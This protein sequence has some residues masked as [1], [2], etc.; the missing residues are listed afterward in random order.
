MKPQEH[1]SV[2]EVGD[3]VRGSQCGVVPHC[4]S[5]R[6]FILLSNE[7]FENLVF[8]AP[9]TSLSYLKALKLTGFD[10]FMH[11]SRR[12]LEEFCCFSNGQET[13][14]IHISRVKIIHIHTIGNLQGLNP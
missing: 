1:F 2:L 11:V 6:L 4:A 3:V 12:N 9:G 14:L 7:E 5:A 10:E 13:V 8:D